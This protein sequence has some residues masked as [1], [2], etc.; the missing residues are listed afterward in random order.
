MQDP[1]ESRIVK[2]AHHRAWFAV[3][4]LL[5][6]YAVS[7]L[8]RQVISLLVEPIKHDLAISDTQIGILQG[9]AFGVFFAIMGL[10]LGWLADRLDR[11]R[12]IAVAILLWSAMTIASGLSTS[13]GGLLVARIGVG[14][15]EAALVP[16][17]VSLLSEYFPPE[18]RAM[19]LSIFT[20]GISLGL[21]L[22]FVLGGQLIAFAESGVA[23][24]PWLGVWLSRYQPWQVVFQLC[25]AMGLP[26]AA[27]VMLLSEPRRNA[28]VVNAQLPAWGDALRF[29]WMRR[30]VFGPL[31]LATSLLYILSTAFSAWIPAHFVRHFGWSAIA[32]ARTLGFPIMLVAVSG[33]WLSGALGWTL[34]RRGAPDAPLRTMLLGACLLVPAAAAGPL[35]ASPQWALIGVLFGYLAIA[36]T[37]GIA[38]TALAA[39]TPAL[40]RGQVV[41]IYLLCGNL[42]GLGVGPPL[43]GAIADHG[44]GQW[45]EIG[46]ALA[47]VCIAT[48]VPAV[49]LFFRVR[50][51]FA[52]A[53]QG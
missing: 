28:M 8:D 52:G 29:M 4:V 42:I 15:G 9:P 34:S 41:A 37:F 7:F 21:G 22:S 40:M 1:A 50:P 45:A 6:S 25:G 20:S 23:S 51:K 12:L 39:I 3:A 38:T 24:L 47:A 48:S 35:A 46:V 14:V 30:A 32:T 18:R 26:V 53:L 11:V 27:V 16:A 31:L 33:N 5:V 13:F 17:A 43:V 44:A 2:A 36:L 19:P 10:P 49:W